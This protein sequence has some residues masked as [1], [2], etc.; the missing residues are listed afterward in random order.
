[1]RAPVAGVSEPPAR[2]FTPAE[3]L[4]VSEGPDRIDPQGPSAGDPAGEQARSEKQ[5]RDAGV[6][7]DV[8]RSR[9]EEKARQEP[10]E[11]G[12]SGKARG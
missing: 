12:G 11:D 1:M 2:R 8:E 7:D 4:F 3:E 10:R 9:L 5:E 6:C